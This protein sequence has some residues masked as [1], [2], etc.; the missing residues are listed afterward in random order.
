MRTRR[1]WNRSAFVLRA[2]LLATCAPLLAHAQSPVLDRFNPA[3]SR[4]LRA[5]EATDAAGAACYPVAQRDRLAKAIRDVRNVFPT[6]RAKISKTYEEE[7]AALIVSTGGRGQVVNMLSDFQLFAIDVVDS[8]EVRCPAQLATVGLSA[9]RPD[10]EDWPEFAAWRTYLNGVAQRAT[11]YSAEKFEIRYGG[12]ETLNWAEVYLDNWMQR[13]RVF[14]ATDFKP[15]PFE[16]I[17]RLTPLVYYDRTEQV[18]SIGEAGMNYYFFEG[19]LKHINPVGI[20]FVLANP[21]ARH[22]FRGLFYAGD[23][24]PG[25]M[26]HA[27]KLEFGVLRGADARYRLIST[28]NIQLAAGVF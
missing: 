21:K 23:L 14:G 13:I 10:A 12:G 25:V 1:S 15:S 28:V 27:R 17:L 18:I 5:A 8:M 11:E 19:M 2:V 6:N 26:V 7:F 24:E 9:T 20:A 4:V 16:P 3:A 22:P